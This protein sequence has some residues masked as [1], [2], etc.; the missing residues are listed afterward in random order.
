MKTTKEAWQ[1]ALEFHGHACPGLAIGVRAGLLAME[2]LES[3]YGSLERD[4][5]EELLAVVETDAC[6]S[7]GIQI[8]TG[9][10][11]GKG[12]FFFLDHG[13]QAFT[14]GVRGKEKALRVLMQPPRKQG[15]REMSREE[16]IRYILEAPAESICQYQWVPTPEPEKA[17][18]FNSVQC[19]VCGEYFMEPRGRIQ[20]GKT[21]CLRCY[22]PY[23]RNLSSWGSLK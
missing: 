11:F 4:Q 20:E 21:V 2:K 5:D 6:S 9:C 19:E 16:R 18:V 10:T 12:N 7:D 15:G 14:V 22:Q 13:K 3:A 1:K 23:E 17:R 8:V